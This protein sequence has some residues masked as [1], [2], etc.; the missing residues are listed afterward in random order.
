MTARAVAQLSLLAELCLPYAKTGG[1]FLAMKSTDSDEELQTAE[2]AI[3]TLGGRLEETWD[4]E[5]PTAGVTHRVITLRKVS[6][7]PA[8]YPRRFGLMKKQPL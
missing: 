2:K 4:Y 8:K 5:I 1:L 6:P 3:Q 7:T